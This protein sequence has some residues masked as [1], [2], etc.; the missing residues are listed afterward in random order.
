MVRG[1]LRRFRNQDI[2]KFAN[3]ITNLNFLICVLQLFNPMLSFHITIL[4]ALNLL[5]MYRNKYLNNC[6]QTYF[7]TKVGAFITS[8]PKH[9][10]SNVFEAFANN[11]LS[12][13]DK[14]GW[15]P[16]SALQL[17]TREF[18]TARNQQ[19]T[20]FQSLMDSRELSNYF[21]SI[22]IARI[23]RLERLNSQINENL[24]ALIT[25]RFP[26]G[27]K[28]RELAFEVYTSGTRGIESRMNHIL[29][30]TG[31]FTY[32]NMRRVVIQDYLR[33]S[34]FRIP[35]LPP[36]HSSSQF[37]SQ[38]AMEAF[39]ESSGLGRIFL[40]HELPLWRNGPEI[41]IYYPPREYLYQGQPYFVEPENRMLNASELA[42][43]YEHPDFDESQRL[44]G[45]LNHY[46]MPRS[47]TF[48]ENQDL[49][50]EYYNFRAR[51]IRIEGTGNTQ[52]VIPFQRLRSIE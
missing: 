22:P 39:L 19:Y 24:R 30:Y 41:P 40:E 38:R 32:P 13:V 5:L 43:L 1:S 12:F 11:P 34:Y 8:D 4:L 25:Q 15:A 45:F 21:G 46:S 49:Q 20:I 33:G 42:H 28:M 27:C 52:V 51:S 2:H 9:I 3:K 6:V 48:P 26:P 47:W 29:H 16:E 18:G 35:D 23:A 10:N 36:L 31:P 44:R 14:N 7:E 17:L 50:S 37:L